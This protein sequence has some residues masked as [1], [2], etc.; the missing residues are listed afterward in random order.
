MALGVHAFYAGWDF[1]DADSPQNG[2]LSVNNLAV[3]G[4]NTI[5]DLSTGNIP[6][7]QQAYTEANTPSVHFWVGVGQQYHWS[8]QDPRSVACAVQQVLCQESPYW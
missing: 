8:N 2:S 5:F 3:N 4:A 6:A 7:N 1:D